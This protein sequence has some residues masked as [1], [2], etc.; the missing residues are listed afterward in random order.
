MVGAV[1]E[2]RRIR[3]NGRLVDKE[4]AFEL[5]L[6]TMIGVIKDQRSH[7]DRKNMLRP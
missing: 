7:P 1:K 5:T 6:E 2:N 4:V 3:E